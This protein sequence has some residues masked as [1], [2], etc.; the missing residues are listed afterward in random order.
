MMSARREPAKVLA[1]RVLGNLAL[2]LVVVF[3]AFTQKGQEL[4]V[5]LFMRAHE[6]LAAYLTG[7]F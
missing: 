1:M 3:L 7:I 5:G 2:L 4:T 6:Q